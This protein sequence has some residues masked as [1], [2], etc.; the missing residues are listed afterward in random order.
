MP[1]YKLANSNRITA[2]F[3][4]LYQSKVLSINNLI[5]IFHRDD[6]AMGYTILLHSKNSATEDQSWQNSQQLSSKELI[7]QKPL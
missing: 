2:C 6:R 7:I 1:Q 3:P 5:I 4:E